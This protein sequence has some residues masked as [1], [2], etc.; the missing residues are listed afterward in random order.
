MYVAIKDTNNNYYFDLN[1]AKFENGE[2]PLKAIAYDK[3]GNKKELT[4]TI[5]A[6]N[7]L[8]PKEK[9]QKAFDLAIAEQ[10]KANEIIAYFDR[11]GLVLS[12]DLNA[13]KEEA[14]TLI[15]SASMQINSAPETALTK[16]TSAL[17]LLQEFNKKAVVET[18]DTKNYYYDSNN[19]TEQLK[20]AGVSEANMQLIID[21]I[22]GS[23]VE[24]KIVILK[25]GAENMR[26]AKV[27]ITFT[28]DTNSD[29]IKIVEMIPKEFVT[30]AK[31]IISDA[32]FR[33]VKEDPVIEFTINAP[34]GSKA[35]FSY[36]IGEITTAQA[37]TIID[38][39]VIQKFTTPPIL[40]SNTSKAEEMVQDNAGIIILIAIIFGG[41]ILFIIFL[42]IVAILFFIKFSHPSHGFGE[43]KTIVEHLTPEQEAEKKKW[44]ANK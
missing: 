8:S 23:G 26:Q 16:A 37:N 42:I 40:I 11:E 24:R 3:A 19:L 4:R 35:S 41:V 18:V 32:N 27:T 22:V 39:N 33:I 25:A 36:G 44:E 9:A 20:S 5:T 6:V 2:Y 29:V 17:T 15:T 10:K 21:S 12:S 31:M 30:S 13:S 1:S 28:N 34:K 43:G 14:D 38:N 7:T